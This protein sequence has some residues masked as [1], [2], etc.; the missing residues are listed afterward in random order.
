MT[1]DSDRLKKQ[2]ASVR[3]QMTAIRDA[4]PQ[5]DRDRKS[6][7][8]AERLVPLLEGRRTVMVFLSFRTEISTAP[9]AERLT[10]E[11]HELALPQIVRPVPEGPKE[12]TPVAWTPGEPLVEA[13]FGIDLPADLRPIPEVDIDAVLIPGL[14]YDRS[15]YRIGY[16]GGFYDRFLPRLRPGV[17]RIGIGFHEQVVSEVPHGAIDERLDLLVTDAG[18]LRFD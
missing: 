13:A 16:G 3:V 6:A 17:P 12:I 4:M 1:A 18:V 5:I 11:G 7:L 10:A 15:G 14:A 9:I 8:V 2:K